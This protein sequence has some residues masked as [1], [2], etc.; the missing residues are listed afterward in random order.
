MGFF[1]KCCA[2]SKLPVVASHRNFPALNKVVVLLPDGSKLA[3]RYDGYGCVGDDEIEDMEG[4]KFVLENHYQGEN[5][6]DLPDSEWEIGQGYFLSEAFLKHCIAVGS[7]ANATEYEQAFN[8][9][10]C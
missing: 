9:F 3:G 1:S 8:Q 4:A 6:S 7:F 2:K 10:N 5:Y